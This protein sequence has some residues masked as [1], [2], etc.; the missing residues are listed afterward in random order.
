MAMAD[1][2]EA[3]VCATQGSFAAGGNISGS[4]INATISG[5][6]GSEACPDA[7]KN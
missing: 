2:T 7:G 4:T 6:T 5:N 3:T 1:H